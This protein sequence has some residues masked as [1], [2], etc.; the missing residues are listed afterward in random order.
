M[1]KIQIYNRNIIDHMSHFPLEQ[2]VAVDD[3]SNHSYVSHHTPPV[4]D[5]VFC[6]YLLALP[7]VLPLK[8]TVVVGD[9]GRGGG[10]GNETIGVDDE[11]LPHWDGIA[12]WKATHHEDAAEYLRRMVEIWWG[13]KWVEGQS[14]CAQLPTVKSVRNFRDQQASAVPFSS[15]ENRQCSST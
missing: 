8:M 12:V 2:F 13:P 4:V 3:L 10:S 14:C 6:L 1:E 7:P 9:G 11:V 5:E 15:R